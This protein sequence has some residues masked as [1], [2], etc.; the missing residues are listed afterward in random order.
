MTVPPYKVPQGGKFQ[1][2]IIPTVDSIRNNYLLT[3]YISM[4]S[5]MLL[6]GPTGTGKTVNVINE[7]STYIYNRQQLP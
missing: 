3:L 7:I 4:K 6:T 2:L 1:E 5:H